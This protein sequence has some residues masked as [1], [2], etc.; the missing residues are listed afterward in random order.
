[1]KHFGTSPH[2]EI[3]EFTL[4]NSGGFELKVINYGCTI[5]SL[6]MP[7]R[8]GKFG[9]VVLGFDSIEDYLQSTHYPGSIIGRYANRI[10]RGEFLLENKK[11]TLPKNQ[12]SHHLHGGYRGFDKVVWQAH[13]IENEKGL[14]VEFYYLSKDGEEGYPGNLSVSV[15][16]FLANENALIITCVAKTDAATIINLTQHSYF[17]LNGSGDILSHQLKINSNYFLPVDAMMIPTG[18]IQ[19]VENNAFDFR[20]LKEIGKD[21]HQQDVQLRIGKGYD[22][23]YVLQKEGEELAH[24]A[25]LYSPLSGRMMELHTTEPGLQ[26]YTANSLKEMSGEHLR[27]GPHAG[28]CLEPQHFPDSPNHP[29]FPSVELYPGETYQSTTVLIFSTK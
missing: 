12:G 9:N 5:T 27:Y 10:S 7:D 19:F 15:R 24:A 11:Y 20:E 29:D 18:E 23:T 4:I 28:V 1:M 25:T 13:A 14:G 17:N 6:K 3:T 8:H 16:Y 21:L 22:H 2:G 26:L